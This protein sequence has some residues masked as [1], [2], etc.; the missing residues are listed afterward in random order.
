MLARARVDVRLITKA[1]HTA[2]KPC[3]T[4]TWHIVAVSKEPRST[5]PR[6][7]AAK[8]QRRQGRVDMLLS[9][10]HYKVYQ[11][12]TLRGP[13]RASNLRFG[14]TTLQ[15]SRNDHLESRLQRGAFS[16]G[17]DYDTAS[18]EGICNQQDTKRSREES[19]TEGDCVTADVDEERHDHEKV[20][21]E[22]VKDPVRRGMQHISG[23]FEAS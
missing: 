18:N 21:E 5:G 13:T 17:R 16:T 3:L 2:C 12:I 1:L 7:G 10:L 20:P 22:E 8:L 14:I 9:P 23:M 15:G 4:A 19:V 6:K 11:R